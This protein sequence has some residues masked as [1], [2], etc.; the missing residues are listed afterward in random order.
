MLLFLLLLLLSMSLLLL[1][2]VS[3]C[4][5]CFVVCLTRFTFYKILLCTPLAVFAC[6]VVAV[7]VTVTLVT[8]VVVVVL[9]RFAGDSIFQKLSLRYAHFRSTNRTRQ[10]SAPD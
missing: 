10:L 7:A 2:L 1:L 5:C 3:F 9:V 6:I 8:V 4:C